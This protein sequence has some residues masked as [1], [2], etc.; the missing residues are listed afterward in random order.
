L[1]TFR[2]TPVND[3]DINHQKLVQNTKL[4][5]VTVL[6]NAVAAMVGSGRAAEYVYTDFR[7][8]TLLIIKGEA[9]AFEDSL[10]LTPAKP[11]AG[12]GV[13]LDAKQNVRNGFQT[14]FQLRISGRGGSGADGM[15]FVIQNRPTPAIGYLGCNLGY[16]GLSNLLVVKFDDYHWQDHAPGNFDEVAVLTAKSA[17]TKLWDDPTNTLAST[18]SGVVF[19][20]G[21]IHTV[22]IVYVPGNLQVFLDDLENPLMTVYVN[23]AR[24]LN[25][26][27]GRAWVGLVGS[28]GDDYQNQDLVSWSFAA[29]DRAVEAAPI[30]AAAQP[31]ATPVYVGNALDPVPA[32]LPI[33]PLFGYAL[34][35]DV[36]APGLI[37]VSTDL[38]H[39]SPLTNATFY[40]RDP[41]S[42]DHPQRFY[43]FRKN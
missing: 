40:F 37:E 25:L 9:V 33:D 32:Q 29:F 35:S 41:E 12:G 2:P 8:P 3:S 24:V 20:D 21:Q 15:A 14:T 31:N 16:G 5:R 39:W 30:E 36:R 28:T 18:T 13:W 34:P 6:I 11:G 38:V 19:S 22:R 1:N 7:E 27:D 17:D 43:R 4:I 10:R 23:L 42:P 26:D